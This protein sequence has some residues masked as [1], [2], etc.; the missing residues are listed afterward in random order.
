MDMSMNKSMDMSIDMSMNMSMN[1]SMDI[2]M[3]MSMDISMLTHN[4]L[5]A[6]YCRSYVDQ[7]FVIYFH[8]T[9]V[10]I[11][12]SCNIRTSNA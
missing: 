8:Y 7:H 4:Q 9:N 6:A 10:N 12:I 5:R 3:N 1:M 11:S 2:S